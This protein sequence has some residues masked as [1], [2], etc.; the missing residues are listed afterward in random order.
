[1]IPPFG[2]TLVKCISNLTTHLKCLSVV[3][4]QVAGYSEHTAMA[5]LYGVLRPGNGKIN[6]CHK[7]HSAKQVTLPK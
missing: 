1:M 5:R 7:N 4:E 2:T 6:V 3:T